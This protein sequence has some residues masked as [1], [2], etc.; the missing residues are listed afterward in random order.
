[1]P[2]PAVDRGPTDTRNIKGVVTQ[3][4]NHGGYKVGTKVGVI[5]GYLSRNQ[6]EFCFLYLHLLV[7]Q[8][9]LLQLQ[10]KNP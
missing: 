4:N 2:I 7:L 8:L 10:W 6:I 3:V 1:M 9:P 5:K